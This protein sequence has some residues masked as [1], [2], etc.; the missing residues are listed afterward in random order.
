MEFCWNDT[1]PI[2][3]QIFFMQTLKSLVQTGLLYLILIIG[4][5]SCTRN[6]LTGKKQLTILPEA[7]IQSLASGQYKDFLKTHP[8]VAGQQNAQVA[9]VK[10]V[11]ERITQA[12]NRYYAGKNMSSVLT[13]YKW[14]YNLVDDATVNAWCMP[15]G[16]I[17]VYTGLLPISMNE[18]ALAVVTGHEVSHALLQHGNQRMSSSMLQQFGGIT[19]AVALSSKPVQTQNL[20]LQAYGIGS[21]VGVMLPFSR[22]HELEA[23][24]YG[25]IWAAMA[26]Y[27]PNEALAFWDRMEKASGGNQV[28]DF[29]RTH[30]TDAVRKEKIKSYLPEALTYKGK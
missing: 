9:M 3:S 5:L 18:N 14:E 1:Q 7:E 23:D 6:A 10:R 30:P 17:V 12:V 27:D 11:G 20:F 29:L 24:R 4:T 21:E 22:K 13:G 2:P 28:P 8:L 19:L 15:G 26:G 16:K 25:L